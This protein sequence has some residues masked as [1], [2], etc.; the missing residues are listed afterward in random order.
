[1]CFVDLCTFSRRMFFVGLWYPLSDTTAGS[2]Q[3][4]LHCWSYTGVNY[5]EAVLIKPACLYFT[6]LPCARAVQENRIANQ[7]RKWVP[8]KTQRGDATQHRTTTDALEAGTRAKNAVRRWSKVEIDVGIDVEN[9]QFGDRSDHWKQTADINIILFIYR[10][11]QRTWSITSLKC[12]T[13]RCLDSRTQQS[14][15]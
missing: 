9:K 4:I 11:M 12:F 3:T 15:K 10:G 8:T 13:N 1:M 5:V 2:N 7:T 14:S 6:S